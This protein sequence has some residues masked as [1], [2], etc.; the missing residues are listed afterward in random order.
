MP[1]ITGLV[2]MTASNPEHAIAEIGAL[3]IAALA[4]SKTGVFSLY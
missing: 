2:C 1:L 4:R 3:F